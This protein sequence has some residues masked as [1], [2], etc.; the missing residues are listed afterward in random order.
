MFRAAVV[1]K[2]I[3]LAAPSCGLH[4]GP[5]HPGAKLSQMPENIIPSRLEFLSLWRHVCSVLLHY[6]YASAILPTGGE[7]WQKESKLRIALAENDE[8]ETTDR[9]KLRHDPP[10][11][12]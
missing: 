10:A 9:E 7:L 4:Q 1:A 6:G 8:A 5:F 11:I 12:H 2:A 3:F